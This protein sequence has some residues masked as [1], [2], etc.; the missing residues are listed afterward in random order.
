MSIE[1]SLKN[2]KLSP[3]GLIL[4]ILECSLWLLDEWTGVFISLLLTLLSAFILCISLVVEWIE[5]SKTPSWYY[6]LM[7]Q[8]FIISFGFTLLFASLNGFHF[9]WQKR[10]H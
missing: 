6:R 10:N 2:L 1:N 7:F 4:A 3:I 8:I 9:D 5:A